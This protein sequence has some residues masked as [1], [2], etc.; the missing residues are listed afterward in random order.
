MRRIL[1]VAVLFALADVGA[2]HEVRPGAAA[3]RGA[4][5]FLRAALGAIAPTVSE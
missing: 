4:A 5:V 3:V 2:V 1:Q